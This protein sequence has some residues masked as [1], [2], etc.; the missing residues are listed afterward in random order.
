MNGNERISREEAEKWI[1]F[2]LQD[3][4]D[5]YM[6]YNPDGNYLSLYIIRNK[7]KNYIA[8]AAGNEHWSVDKEHPIDFSKE[9]KEFE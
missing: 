2:G 1:L 4:W 5:D 6:K 7:D 8:F 3:I 9:E